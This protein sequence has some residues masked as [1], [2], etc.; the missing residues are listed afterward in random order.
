MP[1]EPGSEGCI[2]V[3]KAVRCKGRKSGVRGGQEIRGEKSGPM[4][5]VTKP[6]QEE[7]REQG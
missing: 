4:E 2:G 6:E 7:P 1:F 3:Q 5:A